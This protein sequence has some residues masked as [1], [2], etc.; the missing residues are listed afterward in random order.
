MRHGEAGSGNLA[1]VGVVSLIGQRPKPSF[2]GV[3]R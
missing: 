3:P 2:L 1:G